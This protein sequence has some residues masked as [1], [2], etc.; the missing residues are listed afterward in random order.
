[1]NVH[2][3][4]PYLKEEKDK[5]TF[6]HIIHEFSFEN[7]GH[8][9]REHLTKEMRRRLGI[10]YNPLDTT[11]QF[12]SFIPLINPLMLILDGSTLA[13]ISWSNTSSRLLELNITS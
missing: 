9:D 3:L 12:V 11:G 4:V 10:V 6:G 5:H 8:R 1:M 7:E 13:P 2:D